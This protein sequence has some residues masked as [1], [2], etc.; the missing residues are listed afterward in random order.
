MK[1]QS[2]NFRLE[3]LEQ[4]FYVVNKYIMNISQS[5]KPRKLSPN[6]LGIMEDI[7]FLTQLYAG[8]YTENGNKEKDLEA[9]STDQLVLILHNKKIKRNI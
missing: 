8:G 4:I 7:T 9:V 3:L 6:L 5:K 2:N 1:K